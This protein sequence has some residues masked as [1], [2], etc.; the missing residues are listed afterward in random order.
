MGRPTALFAIRVISRALPFY[1][2]EESP[3]MLIP[4]ALH[5][6]EHTGYGVT[7]PDL[8]GCFSYGETVEEAVANAK[9]AA[10]FHIDGMIEDGMFDDLK[11]SNIQDLQ[12]QEDFKDAVWLLLEIDPAKISQQ[13]TRFNVSW[14]QYLLD[15]VDEYTAIHHETRS[16]FL[17]KAALK[18]INQS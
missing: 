5:K 7:V 15:R 14:P 12:G 4:I 10:Y 3:N 6:D 11:A 18:L 9:E 2:N 1:K 16:G 8:P 17:A 13:Q